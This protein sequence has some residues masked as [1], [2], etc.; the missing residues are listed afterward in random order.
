MFN[1]E[2]VGGDAYN[3]IIG[4]S[5]YENMFVTDYMANGTSRSIEVNLQ[6]NPYVTGKE[7]KGFPVTISALCDEAEGDILIYLGIN[8][9]ISLGSSK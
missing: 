1:L 8:D 9:M 7:E 4:D 2:V 3:V 6:R 5:A